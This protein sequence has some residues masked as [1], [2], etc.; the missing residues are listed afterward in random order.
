MKTNK[1]NIY[2]GKLRLLIFVSLA[3]YSATLMAQT[4]DKP[5]IELLDQRIYEVPEIHWEPTMNQGDIKALFYETLSYKGKPTRA[6]AYIGIPKSDKPVPAM[7]L[8]HG[9]GGKAFHEWVKIWNDRGYAAISM[10]LEGHMPDANGK[11]KFSHDYSGPTRVGRFDDVDLPLD[12]QWMYHAVSDIMI[13]H[14]LIESFPEV[15]ANNIGITGIS[16]GGILSSLV[17]GLDTRLKCAIPVYGCGYLY[18]SKGH[19]GKKRNNTLEFIEKKKFWDPSHQFSIGL[20][21]TLWVNGDSDGHFSINI[22]SHSFKTTSNHAYMTIHP[23]MKHGHP[24]GWRPEDVPEIYDFADY[25]LKGKELGLGKI[26]KQPSKREI[27]LVYESDVPILEAT[28]YYL[29]EKLTYRKSSP[30]SKHA[31]PG[32]WLSMPAKVN[33]SKN[34]VKAE[35]LKTAVT[36]YVNLKD[37]R[38]R[39]ISSVLVDLTKQ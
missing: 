22:T 2:T 7:V 13:G 14:S 16:W 10:S 23:S 6:F 33:N 34:E 15:D 37:S 21:P 39:I 38:G 3:L 18:E 19:F 24:P 27:E 35:L 36:Y 25:I 1:F 12:E 31:R 4:I 20:V 26:V 28:V 29:N 32:P 17:S 9:G 30:K 11:G 5:L 8:V